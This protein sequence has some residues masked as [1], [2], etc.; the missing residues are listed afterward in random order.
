MPQMSEMTPPQQS[1]AFSGHQGK[2]AGMGVCLCQPGRQT[3][4]ILYSCAIKEQG[5]VSEGF[6]LKLKTTENRVGFAA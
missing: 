1:L 6:S 5:E 4:L 2:M 3:L